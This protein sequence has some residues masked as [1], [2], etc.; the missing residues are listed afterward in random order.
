MTNTLDCRNLPCPQPVLRTKE[1]IEK[2]RPET[3]TVIVDNPAARENVTRFMQTQGYAVTESRDGALWRLAASR[4]GEAPTQHADNVVKSLPCPVD[5][6]KILLVIP[7]NLFGSGDDDLGGRLMK[8][9]LL[10]LPEMGESLWR[11]ILLNG[12]VKLSITGSP[13]L[14][15]LRIL[16][17]QG[18]SILVCGSCL[19]FYGLMDQKAVGETTNML[20][21]V[22]SMQV[23]D[24]VL[25]V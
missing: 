25:R 22:T 3:F 13:V 6:E 24:K 9:F 1:L 17:K 8:N 10:T 7:T 11:I 16:Q 19:D 14:E 12:G 5:K 21:V 23:A 20:D 4:T 2:N 15:E 18:V